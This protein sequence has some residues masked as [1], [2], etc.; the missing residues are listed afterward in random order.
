M[1][2]AP[3]VNGGEAERGEGGRGRER[4]GKVGKTHEINLTLSRCAVFDGKTELNFQD[5]LDFQMLLGENAMAF[6]KDP[7]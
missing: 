3:V 5:F 2:V 7:L 4:A 6:A 1:C